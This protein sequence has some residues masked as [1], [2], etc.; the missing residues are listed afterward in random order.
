M[1]HSG[2]LM[3]NH[4]SASFAAAFILLSM[5]T[6]SDPAASAASLSDIPSGVPHP[7]DSMVFTLAGQGGNCDTCEWIA[8]E[9]PITQR[10]PQDFEAFLRLFGS[11]VGVVD[12]RETLRLDSNGGNLVAGLEL[13]EAIRAHRLSTEVGRTVAGPSVGNLTFEATAPGSC[14][15][16]CAMRFW[17]ESGAR[18]AR[19]SW[20]FISFI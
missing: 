9:G 17:V 19:E 12:G 14:A 7:A 4:L 1:S 20:G 11:A 15:S 5:T 8:A 18:P 3:N 6:L 13:G 16:A 10:T 2:S